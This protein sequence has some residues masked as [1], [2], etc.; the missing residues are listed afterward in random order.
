MSSGEE[1]EGDMS[2][3]RVAWDLNI[4]EI[5]TGSEVDEVFRQGPTW[6]MNSINTI[7]YNILLTQDLQGRGLTGHC[8][9]N[10]K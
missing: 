3:N 8:N 7:I 6:L 10:I 9:Y 4:Q 5:K 2:E 1:I